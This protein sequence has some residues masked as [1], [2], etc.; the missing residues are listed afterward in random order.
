MLY[1]GDAFQKT[2]LPRKKR[3]WGRGICVLALLLLI[4]L[5]AIG[6]VLFLQLIVFPGMS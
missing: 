4:T 3:P 5:V 2:V 1:G 6:A